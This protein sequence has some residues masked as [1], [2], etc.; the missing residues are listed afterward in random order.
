MKVAI[1]QPGYLPWL[2]FF[3]LMK[4]C[5]LFVIY[6]DVKYTKNDWRNRNKIKTPQGECWL[7]IPVPKG[8]SKMKIN[9]VWIQ[10]G[11]G[12][13]HLETIQMAYSKAKYFEE[14]SNAL[15][16]N[17]PSFT[18][19]ELLKYV[20]YH[21][22]KIHKYLDLRCEIKFSSRIGF[23][24]YSSTERL[25]LLC[26]SLGATEYISPNGALPYLDKDLFARAGIKL[27][28]QDYEHPVY[29]QLWGD[30]IPNMSIID[31]LFNHGK[32]SVDI[33]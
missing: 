15:F 19:C 7:T 28:W 24:R 31:L 4:R 5:H 12:N 18:A 9:N 3:N 22:D 23:S 29:N 10:G 8:S 16:H 21:I 14:I 17:T 1:M 13:S 2:G 25:I 33:I 32:E 6:D 26:Q 20:M 30:F 27:T 11:F